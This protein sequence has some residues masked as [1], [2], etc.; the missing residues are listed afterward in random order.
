MVL[1]GFEKGGMPNSQVFALE[2][3]GIDADEPDDDG[4]FAD[5]MTLF[6]L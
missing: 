6:V 1:G 2:Y 5:G 4:T 3:P